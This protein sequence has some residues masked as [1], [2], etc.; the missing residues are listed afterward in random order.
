MNSFPGGNRDKD[1]SMKAL[2]LAAGLGRRLFGDDNDDLPKALLRFEGKT[3]LHRHIEILRDFGIDELVMVVG[4]RKEDLLAEVEAVLAAGAAPEGFVRSIFNPRYK[5][6]PIL[7]LW[8]AADELRKGD[9]TLFMDA[10]VL[11]HPE[12]MKR[13]I[14]SPMENCFVMDSNLDEGEDPVMVCIRDGELV[15]FG[16]LITGDFDEIGEW[17]GFLKMSPDIAVKLADTAQAFVDRGE[18][19]AT[20]EPAMREVLVSEPAGTFGY[21]DISDVPWIEI[22]FPSDLLRAEK[23]ILPLVTNF[24]PDEE[25][26]SPPPLKSRATAE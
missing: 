18:I 9:E 26:A 23:I 5:E 14:T 15:D 7:S 10:D 25:E 2:M 6:A 4:H 17:P 12:M 20:Y 3:L 8:T 1:H 16:K 22:D 19:E 21:E 24:D 11:Y 13:L